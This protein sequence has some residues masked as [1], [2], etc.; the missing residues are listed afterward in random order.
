M[1][2]RNLINE[3]ALDHEP[4]PLRFGDEDDHKYE[5]WLEIFFSY[6]QN[7]DSPESFILPFFLRKVS[8]VILSEGSYALFRSQNDKGRTIRKVMGG[9]GIFEPQEF[10]FRYQTPCMNFF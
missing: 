4:V 8:T 3:H 10:F 5:I 7:I 6:S 2:K 1:K 9:R